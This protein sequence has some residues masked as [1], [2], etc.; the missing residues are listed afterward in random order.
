M[1]TPRSLL[2]IY[3]PLNSSS[4]ALECQG[5]GV[6]ACAC[7]FA[8]APACVRV[9]VQSFV[10]EAVYVSGCVRYSKSQQ[11][12]PYHMFKMYLNSQSVQT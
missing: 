5:E 2:K 8:C 4:G 11:S 12:G 3:F 1:S 10:W 6:F 9:D 7:S